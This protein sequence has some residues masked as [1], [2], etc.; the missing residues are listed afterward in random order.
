M[1]ISGTLEKLKYC[2]GDVLG[3]LPDKKENGEP[4]VYD[5]KITEKRKK[6]TLDANA[7]YWALDRKSVV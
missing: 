2:V 6:R 4:I 1:I 7:Y 3:H 5:L